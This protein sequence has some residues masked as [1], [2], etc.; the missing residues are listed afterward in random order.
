V[1]EVMTDIQLNVEEVS[2]KLIHDIKIL[3]EEA[4]NSIAVSSNSV[5]VLLYWNVGDRI[6]REVLGEERAEYGKAI[7]NN[8]SKELTMGY[9]RGFARSNIFKMIQF[10][11]TFSNYDIVRSLSRQLRWSHF[12]EILTLKEPIQ[13]EF[14][15][16]LCRIE[17]WD[18]RSLRKKIQGMLFE[19]TALSKNTETF[20]KNELEQVRKN[21]ELTSAL[22]FRDPY[23]LDFL[24][25]PRNYSEKDLENAILEELSGFIQEFGSDFCFVERQKR[26]SIGDDDFY[27]DLLFFNR[28]LKRLIAIELK[29]EKFSASHKGQMELYLRWLNKYERKEGENAPLGLILCSKKNQEQVELLEMNQSGI[30]VAEYLTQLPPKEVLENKLHQAIIAARERLGE[31]YPY[32]LPSDEDK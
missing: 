20:I 11:K 25:L 27:I 18:V 1:E 19:R 6:N 28:S 17:G 22:I 31:K 2:K 5:M 3:I 10:S 13:R 9:G 26:I 16:E 32:L 12:L 23:L 24:N 15:A 29:L 8:V 14:Y 21:D 30:H 7:V 4:K